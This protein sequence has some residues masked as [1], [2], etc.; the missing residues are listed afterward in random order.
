MGET[1]T[2]LGRQAEVDY[3][4]SRLTLLDDGA[5]G[6]LVTGDSG[7]G[8]STVLQSAAQ[9]M[10][11]RGVTVLAASCL[12]VGEQ[13]PF[14]PIRTALQRADPA[15][16]RA[17]AAIASALDILAGTGSRTLENLHDALVQLAR[18]PVVLMLD[19]LQ[20]AD[21]ATRSLVLTLL[22][23]YGDA[24]VLFIGAT[25][26]RDLTDDDGSRGGSTI[27]GMARQLTGRSRFDVVTI[28]PL[29]VAEVEA[30][31]RG[32]GL[33]PTREESEQLHGRTA[34]NPFYVESLVRS[35]LGSDSWA[36][37]DNLRGVLLRDMA[38]LTPSDA[39]I[40]RAVS[41]CPGPVPHEILQA[42]LVNPHTP[43]LNSQ[44]LVD[45][46]R[47]LIAA[48][49][50]V[51]D[52]ND[53]G[54]RHLLLR[55]ALLSDLL[56]AERR[57]LHRRFAE[58]YRDLA[59]SRRDERAMHWREAG[60]PDLAL[61]ELVAAAKEADRLEAPEA[62]WRL[63]RSTVEVADALSDHAA[64]SELLVQ[65]ADAA[66][67]AG[68][69]HAAIELLDRTHS[70]EPAVAVT[71]AVYLAGAGQLTLALDHLDR[72]LE[73]QVLHPEETD[74][75]LALSAEFLVRQGSF[76]SARDRAQ[77]LLGRG[78]TGSAGG[79]AVLARVALGFSEAY[80][81][82]L[83]AG[84]QELQRS[85][86]EA[87]HAG[88]LRLISTAHLYL[89]S[90]LAGPLNDLETGVRVARRGAAALA[91]RGGSG[92]QVAAML[93]TASNGLFRLGRW[94]EAAELV[95]EAVR[96]THSGQAGADLYL[97]RARIVLAMGDLAAAESDIEAAGT[98]LADT[99][100]PAL[101]LPL[102]T[103]RAGL[104]L[105]RSDVATARAAVV[106]GLTMM[107]EDYQDSWQLAP[108]VWHGLRTEALAAT[109]GL[110]VDQQ[111]LALVQ[112]QR[113]RMMD[114]TTGPVRQGV[115]GYELLCAA[116][117]S[118]LV[119][120][121]DPELW[122][123]AAR[124]WDSHTHPYPA[125]Y[126]RMCQAEAM[127][128]QRARNRDAAE[129]LRAAHADAL[130][131]GARLLADQAAGL[132]TRA[133]VSLEGKPAVAPVE[134]PASLAA[135]TNREHEVLA[136]IAQ[137]KT[138]REIAGELFIS[139][140]TVDV[141]VSKVLAKLKVRSRV[142]ASVRFLGATSSPPS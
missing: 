138:N 140:R 112:G 46:L 20:W 127:F 16:P 3:L 95:S 24:K 98:L 49:L 86:A 71:R 74:R 121:P 50:V 123:A 8:K 101:I 44:L 77:K 90:L 142:E 80:L 26:S 91:A 66:H 68:D 17:R 81:G 141:H 52:G 4:L 78:S 122:A 48:R 63:W 34:G 58:A 135:L 1:Q 36:L 11:R 25:R 45:G 117:A 105:W 139:D 119:G 82:N 12:D 126:A 107:P 132:A 23:G 27:A 84:R 118:K 131:M 115:E 124:H 62:A 88:D 54:P 29:S 100:A 21:A 67:R 14:H 102:E 43:Q 51:L 61:P 9:A 22:S 89:A 133:R 33:H 7:I 92:P 111:L 85:L 65:A 136:L 53:Y 96:E 120:L 32:L 2:V 110:A 116:E 31:A 38:R 5:R 19:D 125:A 6:L 76:D 94:S 13:W 108:L 40:L 41:V 87:E 64:T 10:R 114:G 55:E 93:A 79:S 134:E 73:Q 75:A 129:L 130:A 37:P 69:D 57:L 70:T 72:L 99:T 59:P 47:R 128:A 113:A 42:A 56:P 103:L 35:R 15:S 28:G 83:E 137:G 97:A 104:A 18:E 60:L 39:I 106:A 30:M 109:T